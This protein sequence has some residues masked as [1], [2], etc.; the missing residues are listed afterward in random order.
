MAELE[1]RLRDA[2]TPAFTAQLLARRAGP[3]LAVGSVWAA[4]LG[5]DELACEACEGMV[6]P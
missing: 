5:R 3:Q 4:D 6:T 1:T 2:G